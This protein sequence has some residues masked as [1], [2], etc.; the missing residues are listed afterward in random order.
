MKNSK[1]EL[2][3]L[4]VEGRENGGD[5]KRRIVAVKCSVGQPLH[6]SVELTAGHRR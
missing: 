1:K 2:S 6:G 4:R 3:W 5:G